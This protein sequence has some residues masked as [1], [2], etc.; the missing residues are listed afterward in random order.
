MLF[1]FFFNIS[2]NIDQERYFWKYRIYYVFDKYR[3]NQYRINT[4]FFDCVDKINQLKKIL[5]K[6][7]GIKFQRIGVESKHQLFD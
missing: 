4:Y 6:R 5:Y 7:K 3:I 2:H 1:K